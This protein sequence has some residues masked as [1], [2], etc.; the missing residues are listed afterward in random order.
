MQDVPVTSLKLEKCISFLPAPGSD[1]CC[2]KLS[3]RHYSP[4]ETSILALM[5]KFD[6][7]TNNCPKLDRLAYLQTMPRTGRGMRG[8]VASR[9]SQVASRK[10]LRIQ[11]TIT[12]RCTVRG[13]ESMNRRWGEATELFN[14]RG[15]RETGLRFS[16]NPCAVRTIRKYRAGM[17]LGPDSSGSPIVPQRCRNKRQRRGPH[18]QAPQVNYGGGGGTRDSSV[19]SPRVPRTRYRL[20]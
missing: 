17:F 10:S 20:Q 16:N 7:R 18:G 11:A 8:H 15:N 9:K 6:P 5:E 14:R 1:T 3:I 19:T 4:A 12:S 2:E 13:A